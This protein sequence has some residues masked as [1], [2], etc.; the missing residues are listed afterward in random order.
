M[1]DKKV[2]ERVN[3]QVKDCLRSPFQGIGNKNL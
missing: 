2:I 3:D 1:Q